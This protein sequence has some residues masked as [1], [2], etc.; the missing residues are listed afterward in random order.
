MQVIFLSSHEHADENPQLKRLI[1]KTQA[2]FLSKADPSL[3][4]SDYT[5]Q[6]LFLTKGTFAAHAH[7]VNSCIINLDEILLNEFENC[8][9]FFDTMIRKKINPDNL[10]RALK[11]FVDFKVKNEMLLCASL[12]TETKTLLTAITSLN[13][14]VNQDDKSLSAKVVIDFLLQK[15][16]FLHFVIH[17]FE[18]LQKD[19]PSLLIRS[20]CDDNFY[21]K[22]M[23]EFAFDSRIKQID[24]LRLGFF[25]MRNELSNPK[26][27]SALP[28][29]E[30][31]YR[32]VIP[33]KELASY[34]KSNAPL[35]PRII[36][37]RILPDTPNVKL[38]AVTPFHWIRQ[39]F[40]LHTHLQSLD[41]S[42]NTIDART[43]DFLAQQIKKSRTSGG[44]FNTLNM[45]QAIV[46]DEN[47]ILFFVAKE[48]QIFR[49]SRVIQFSDALYTKSHSH[50]ELSEQLSEFIGGNGVK[51]IYASP[52]S[53][54]DVF[55]KIHKN[56]SLFRR[57]TMHPIGY[58]LINRLLS[59]DAFLKQFIRHNL[60]IGAL[61]SLYNDTEAKDNTSA[62]YGLTCDP[63]L[64][65]LNRILSCLIANN[66]HVPVKL[67]TNAAFVNRYKCSQ[68]DI[69]E[70]TGQLDSVIINFQQAMAAGGSPAV[71]K[72]IKDFFIFLLRL[73]FPPEWEVSEND[74][75]ESK[76]ETAS[77]PKK[78]QKRTME[79]YLREDTL[80]FDETRTK[81]SCANFNQHIESI[82]SSSFSKFISEPSFLASF[83]KI[84]NR[85]LTTGSLCGES[86]F[87]SWL[88]H[89]TFMLPKLLQIVAEQGHDPQLLSGALI[90]EALL[91]LSADDAVSPI[92]LIFQKNHP[93]LI[94]FFKPVLI[95]LA[96]TH[97]QEFL[98]LFLTRFTDK[99]GQA[100]SSLLMV[101]LGYERQTSDCFIGELFNEI[102][103]PALLEALEGLPVLLNDP[104]LYLPLC[105]LNS[106]YANNTFVNVLLKSTIRSLFKSI[107]LTVDPL[108]FATKEKRAVWIELFNQESF[109]ALWNG[110]VFDEVFAVSFLT[111]CQ[112]SIFP[113]ISSEA[114]TQLPEL[115]KSILGHPTLQV[116]LASLKSKK[117]V[118]MKA[119]AQ[120][121]TEGP[122]GA[123]T[124]NEPLVSPVI[125]STKQV[126]VVT[127][128]KTEPVLAAVSP[129]ELASKKTMSRQ[130]S[131]LN[132]ILSTLTF[133]ESMI[134]KKQLRKISPREIF[135]AT[136]FLSQ[137]EEFL[138]LLQY[139]D[140]KAQTPPSI[141]YTHRVDLLNHMNA[142]EAIYVLQRNE[143]IKNMSLFLQEAC[144]SAENTPWLMR[145]L[146]HNSVGFYRARSLDNKE[147]KS[148]CIK[149]IAQ[150]Q[151][152]EFFR[153]FIAAEV[154]AQGV[155]KNSL[156][157]ERTLHESRAFLAKETNDLD[158]AKLLYL[159]LQ[160]FTDIDLLE[161]S[162]IPDLIAVFNLEK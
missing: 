49:L 111:I 11:H 32:G 6:F 18:V 75:I 109:I 84:H 19:N 22:L 40:I 4:I 14:H 148:L 44:A 112:Q 142:L 54:L 108:L 56:D 57:W 135:E 122:Y 59:D 63:N 104:S 33:M 15:K 154:I 77:A 161:N 16:Y 153:E 69:D 80:L 30:T 74:A 157:P 21:E 146:I 103:L 1:A 152:F 118:G 158:E 96:R 155:R 68:Q 45:D 126:E 83:L 23:N 102:N 47:G 129:G 9:E 17:Y 85:S 162:S 149:W 51:Q 89:D 34:L 144:T 93:S 116:Y 61:T 41:I 52:Q 67:I 60:F 90:N 78:K 26:G 160:F 140:S 87:Y 66:I 42:G 2:I 107:S 81:G 138:S 151:D 39:I 88:K 43:H 131:V 12:E 114:E 24:E 58:E 97:A 53:F 73:P 150:S 117:F 100:G 105:R 130:E 145:T 13:F 95:E 91:C 92:H 10:L 106:Q 36:G 139:I 50:F 28:A 98:A 25:L 46:I 65:A 99:K 29:A 20:V 132:K 120:L 113:N 141:R 110:C 79:S 124:L 5:C 159:C 7:E 82:K 55:L 48:S 127:I 37:L 35:D 119:W 27:V 147:V 76:A 62:L 31:N 115:L 72:S 64:L 94:S 70:Q 125:S 3:E 86:V 121:K 128:K 133:M 38:R 143:P 134:Q 101:L 156:M 123:S 71:F 137:P 136:N 8:L